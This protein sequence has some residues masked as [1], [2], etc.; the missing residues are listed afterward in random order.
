M[1][2]W[3]RTVTDTDENAVKVTLAPLAAAHELI[4]LARDLLKVPEGAELSL[5]YNN[6]SIDLQRPLDD[7]HNGTIVVVPYHASPKKRCQPKRSEAVRG[8]TDGLQ[9]PAGKADAKEVMKVD[10]WLIAIREAAEAVKAAADAKAAVEKDVEEAKKAAAGMKAAAIREAAEAVKVAMEG[11]RIAKEMTAA[12][13]KATEEELIAALTEAEEAVKA[14][15]EAKAAVEKDSIKTNAPRIKVAD[16]T[17]GGGDGMPS[18]E[19]NVSPRLQQIPPQTS[20]P[21]SARKRARSR[22]ESLFSRTLKSKEELQVQRRWIGFTFVA[23]GAAAGL[24]RFLYQTRRFRY[25][26]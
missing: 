22:K 13:A 23:L 25:W 7:L 3:L 6:E 21:M 16:D 4:P 5:L 10:D 1:K 18:Q 9:S 17:I 8:G 11:K 19:E 12:E 24:A 15:A 20:L 2:I 26:L 14:A